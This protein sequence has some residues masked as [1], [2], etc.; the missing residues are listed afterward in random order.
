VLGLSEEHWG[1]RWLQVLVIVPSVARR[2]ELVALVKDMLGTAWWPWIG[3]LTVDAL[4]PGRFDRQ[5]W[6]WVDGR[7]AR[8]LRTPAPMAAGPASL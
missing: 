7:Q 3:F 6:Q 5:P 1:R 2:D 8:L 4:D